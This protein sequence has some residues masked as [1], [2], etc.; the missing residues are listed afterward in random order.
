L[1]RAVSIPNAGE[2]IPSPEAVAEMAVRF[3]AE[4]VMLPGEIDLIKYYRMLIL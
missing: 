4:A 2:S 1:K 3:L